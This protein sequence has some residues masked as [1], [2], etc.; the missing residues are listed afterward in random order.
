MKKTEAQIDLGGHG[1]TLNTKYKPPT[2]TKHPRHL[3]KCSRGRNIEKS[4]Q[5]KQN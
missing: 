2:H 4:K 1:T 3:K 5:R